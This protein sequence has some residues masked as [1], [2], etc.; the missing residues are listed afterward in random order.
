MTHFLG[1]IGPWQVSLII[2]LTIVSIILPIIALIDI[3]RKPFDSKDKLIWVLIVL[4][5]NFFGSL[6]YFI[7]GRRQLN[8]K[9]SA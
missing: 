6:L 9:I 1:M 4:F 7:M 5:A 3:I 8:E 2:I